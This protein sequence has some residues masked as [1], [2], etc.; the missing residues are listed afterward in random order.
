MVIVVV[1][2]FFVVVVVFVVV[3]LVVLVLVVLKVR[4]FTGFSGR[5]EVA[6][7]SDTSFTQKPLPIQESSLKTSRSSVRN[8]TARGLYI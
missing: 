2:T 3:V 1:V 5:C 6:A 4:A 8:K 7:G